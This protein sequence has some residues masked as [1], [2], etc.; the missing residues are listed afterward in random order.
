MVGTGGEPH[1]GVVAVGYPILC[2][3]GLITNRVYKPT[4]FHKPAKEM[5]PNCVILE[6]KRLHTLATALTQTNL[7]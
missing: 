4:V 3:L 7:M 2:T 6:L 1:T 5:Y